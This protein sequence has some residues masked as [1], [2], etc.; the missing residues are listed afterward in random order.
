MGG[1]GGGGGG[2]KPSN[3]DHVLWNFNMVFTNNGSETDLVSVSECESVAGVGDGEGV[4]RIQ[5]IRQL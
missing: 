3:Y 5:R 2:R 1:G 4:V